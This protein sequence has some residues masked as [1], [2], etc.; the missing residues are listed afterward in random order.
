MKISGKY[1]LAPVLLGSLAGCMSSSEGTRLC[2]DNRGGFISCQDVSSVNV[3]QGPEAA[4]IETRSNQK[5]LHSSLYSSSLHFQLLSDYTEQM[6]AEL[7]RDLA[8]VRINE[9][10]AVASFVHLDAGMRTTSRLGIQLAEFFIH[11]LQAIGLPVMEHR[12]ADELTRD[13]AGDFALERATGSIPFIHNVGYVLVGTLIE[14][15]RGLIINAR[16]VHTK[17]QKV[18]AAS[19]RLLPQA[20]FSGF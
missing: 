16:L 12:L 17:S 6:S 19:S 14:N 18:V 7:E 20:V 8:D 5:T 3:P 10:I 2:A 15:N 4:S 9:K 11:D 1:L 13:M